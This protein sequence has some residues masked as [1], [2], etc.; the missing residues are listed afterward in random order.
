MSDLRVGDECPRC[1]GRGEVYDEVFEYEW[2]TCPYFDFDRRIG[3][4]DGVIATE[5][6]IKAAEDEQRVSDGGED[7]P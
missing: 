7:R 5:A 2:A 3:C 4:L 6:D 1:Y